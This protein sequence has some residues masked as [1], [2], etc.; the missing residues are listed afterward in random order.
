[1]VEVAILQQLLKD[2]NV[3]GIKNFI[4]ENALQIRD[5]KIYAKNPSVVK[6]QEEYYDRRQMVQKICSNSGY[7][8]LLNAASRFNDKR[9]GQS[10]TLNGKLTC[11]YMNCTVNECI[12]GKFEI[13]GEALITAD[14][15][16]ISGD[17]LIDTNNGKLSIEEL[18]VISNSFEEQ[19]EKEFGYNNNLKVRTYDPE[20]NE[21]YFENID[22]VYRHKVSKEQW[23]IEDEEGNKICVTNDHSIMVEREG[24]L[25]ECKPMDIKDTDLLISILE[26]K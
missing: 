9:V 23:E 21:S 14:T 6:Y 16:S 1:M 7:G 3:V 20:T 12:T 24:K 13:D 22:Y 25:I 8:A 4:E 2:K 10:I 19:G 17:S 15:D 26:D 11:K 5:G 18:F